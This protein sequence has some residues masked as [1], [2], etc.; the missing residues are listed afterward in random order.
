VVEV[1]GGMEWDGG[2]GVGWWRYSV[3]GVYGVYGVPE[4]WRRL[5]RMPRCSAQI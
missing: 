5:W 3:Y 2:M 1:D 4:S